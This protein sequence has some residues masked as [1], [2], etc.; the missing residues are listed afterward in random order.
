MEFHI[1][2]DNNQLF[3]STTDSFVELNRCLMKGYSLTLT[4]IKWMN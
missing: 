4:D 2:E 1:N 3:N